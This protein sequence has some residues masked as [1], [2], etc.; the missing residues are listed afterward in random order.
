MGSTNPQKE[1]D[2]MDIFLQAIEDVHLD[3]EVLDQLAH[4]DMRL[5]WIFG[6]AAILIL[7]LACINFINLST[8]RSANRAREVGIRRTT[9]AFRKQLISQFLIESL[10]YSFIS[11][12]IGLVLA[13]YFLP[14]F[15][16]LSGKPLEIPWME[17]WFFPMIFVAALV[18]GLLSGLYP[19]MY[20]SSFKPIQVI[21]G[22]ISRGSKNP[23]L[24]N[25]LVVFQFTAS[26]VLLIGT[27]IVNQ[28][29]SFILNKKIGFEKDQVLMLQGTNTLG[30]KIQTFKEE[31]IALPEI[32]SAS[33][34]AF[35]P[36]EGAQRN[37][38]PFFLTG[39]E[40]S[41]E[42]TNGQQ[43]RVDFDYI[44]TLGMNI[45]EGRDF[46]SEMRTDSQSVVVNQKMVK[47]LGLK[48]PIGQ[49]IDFIGGTWTIIGVVEDFHF[50][51]L[52]QEV[53]PMALWIGNSTSRVCVRAKSTDM[54]MVL[55][56]VKRVWK[57]FAP[58]QPMRY[59]FMDESF[60]RTYE[61]VKRSGN[62]FTSFAG[63][64]IIIACLG[65]FGLTAYIAEQR[66][67][68]IG[69]R[70]VL[71][72]SVRQII[73][74]LSKDFAKLVFLSIL[75]ASPLAWYIMKQWLKSFAYR[76]D[77]QIWIFVAAGCITL[78]IAFLTMSYHSIKTALADPVESLRT[79]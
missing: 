17:P 48:D 1:L 36:V 66:T 39:E 34:T 77:I 12:G 42:E 27:G 9:G 73:E 41:A 29:L 2:E 78:L 16:Q 70:K 30:E 4:G 60:A 71:G 52:R 15:N 10:L 58:N 40:S 11:F 35:L 23:T 50:E 24:R 45:V 21:K 14:F 38:T 79:E 64:A 68:E 67:K 31:L 28:Q 76:I 47:E 6:S 61:D 51:S 13:F 19:A 7:L 3:S 8:A 49:Q 55:T 54:S 43:W 72:A 65:L 63:L 69:I 5:I 32:Q 18:I 26:I 53:R 20:L 74:L 44:Q 37:G 56:K 33:V 25:N 46:N 59:Q 22:A 57:E 62:M 75:I